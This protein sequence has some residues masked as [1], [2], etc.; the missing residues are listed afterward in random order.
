MAATAPVA[1]RWR[2]I[3]RLTTLTRRHGK[4]RGMK[5][6]YWFECPECDYYTFDVKQLDNIK[7]TKEGDSICPECDFTG[8]TYDLREE[9]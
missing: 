5:H 3:A 6:E 9:D 8:T 1:K 7:R 2:A 4:E